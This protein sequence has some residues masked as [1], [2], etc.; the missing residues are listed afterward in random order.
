MCVLDNNTLVYATR[1][2]CPFYLK[3]HQSLT[4][5][6]VAGARR[7]IPWPCAHKFLGVVTNPKFHRPAPPRHAT[8]HIVVMQFLK[9]CLALPSF[10]FIGESRS[11]VDILDK[12]FTSSKAN[13][14]MIYDV[15]TVAFCIHHGVSE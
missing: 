5:L 13:G 4:D 9:N 15:K 1:A 7:T 11:N 6:S 3:A 8:P 12:M 10:N 14:G 2:E